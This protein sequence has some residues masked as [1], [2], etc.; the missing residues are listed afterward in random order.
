MFYEYNDNTRHSRVCWNGG[1]DDMSMEELDWFSAYDVVTI[2]D[3]KIIRTLIIPKKK[4]EDE[5]KNEKQ[6]DCQNRSWI[7]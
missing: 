5:S 6:S 7:H 1:G 3:G 4:K 2:E